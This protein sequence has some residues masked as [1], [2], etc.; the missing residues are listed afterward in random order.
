MAAKVYVGNLAWGTDE[1]ILRQA[2]GVHG[3]VIDVIVMKEPQTGRSRGFGF[4]T[5]ANPQEAEVAIAN[6]NEQQL[7]CASF[8]LPVRLLLPWSPEGLAQWSLSVLKTAWL[9]LRSCSLSS[10]FEWPDSDW[11]CSPAFFFWL[12]PR[13]MRCAVSLLAGYIYRL[14]GSVCATNARFL[15]SPSVG[16]TGWLCLG[17]LGL[18][19]ALASGC[20]ARSGGPPDL[21]RDDLTYMDVSDGRTLRVNYANNR[22]G[23][24]GGG[25][26]AS[27]PGGGMYAG[28]GQPQQSYGQPQGG[29]GGGKSHRDHAAATARKVLLKATVVKVKV[30]TVA[31][32]VAMEVKMA[33]TANKAVTELPRAATAAR[34]PRAAMAVK[35]LRVATA[36]VRPRVASAVLYLLLADTAVRVLKVEVATAEAIP[37]EE[38]VA[39]EVTKNDMN[40]LQARAVYASL[41][42]I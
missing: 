21:Y 28:Y 36:V 39:T 18:C 23:P 37:A 16:P 5:F 25:G 38:V 15:G 9:P 41:C 12:L 8:F 11:P 13:R 31:H 33:D 14:L 3:Q 6:M 34:L 32:K 10:V 4:V 17:L 19:L 1:E 24:G 22:T 42:S 20:S 7:V 26:Y 35:R 29:Y 27:A 40:S 2:F 30:A